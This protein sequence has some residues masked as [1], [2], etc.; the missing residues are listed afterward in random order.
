MSRGGPPAPLQLARKPARGGV[1]MPSAGP[2][3][4]VISKWR[5]LPFVG[6][7]RAFSA[8]GANLHRRRQRVPQGQSWDRAYASGAAKIE[9]WRPISVLPTGGLRGRRRSQHELFPHP[10]PNCKQLARKIGTETSQRA[11]FYGGSTQ[12]TRPEG[13][14][15]IVWAESAGPLA[16]QKVAKRPRRLLT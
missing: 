3:E 5:L 4:G 7:L 15:S 1:G 12:E 11:D 16:S 2:L 10:R 13:R 8:G 6:A 14:A 9:F